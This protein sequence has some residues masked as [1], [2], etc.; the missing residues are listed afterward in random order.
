MSLLQFFKNSSSDYVK[1]F[2][3]SMHTFPALDQLQQQY[4]DGAHPDISTGETVKDLIAKA[5]EGALV[6]AQAEDLVEKNPVIAVE[7][8]T[9]MINSPEFVEYLTVLVTMEM[10]VNSVEVVIKLT[11]AGNL[12][13]E[14]LILCI[15]NFIVSCE[16]IKDRYLQNRLVRLVFAFIQLLIRNH[17]IDVKEVLIEVQAFCINFSRLREAAAL[18]RLLKT[19]EG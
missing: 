15:R 3:P 5:A 4:S 18:F 1:G 14:F 9:K 11:Q 6:P 12:T 8:L 19:I 10:S 2:D 13:C 17:H 7:V 16:N